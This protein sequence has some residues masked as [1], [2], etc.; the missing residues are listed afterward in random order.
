M[1]KDLLI[2]RGFELGQYFV[3]GFAVRPGEGVTLRLPSRLG[4]ADELAAFLCGKPPRPEVELRG[5]CVVAQRADPPDGWRRWFA[6]P[7]PSQWLIRHGFAPD[8]ATAVLVRHRIDDR[9]PLSRYAAGPRTLLGLER[10]YHSGPAIVVFSTSG[11]DPL[12]ESA[13][14]SL[15]RSHLSRTSAVYLAAPYLSGGESHQRELPGSTVV[16]INL[17]PPVAV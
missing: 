10:A 13:V 6:D 4:A 3:P 16:E 8:A 11:L 9:F 5:T 14:H 17:N 15:V 7:T 12:G 2:C 1:A